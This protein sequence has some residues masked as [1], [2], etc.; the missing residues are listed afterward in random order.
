MVVL[1][2]AFETSWK[3]HETMNTIWNF[4]DL[5]P[6]ETSMPIKTKLPHSLMFPNK[7]LPISIS[8]LGWANTDFSDQPTSYPTS[9]P[10]N[11]N[12]Y[13]SLEYETYS[14]V[15]KFFVPFN[16]VFMKMTGLNTSSWNYRTK[17]SY[18]G[19]N[20][21]LATADEMDD[22]INTT[23]VLSWFEI[24]DNNRND[25]LHK[26]SLEYMWAHLFPKRYVLF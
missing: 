8:S 2:E 21:F 22:V 11:R 7:S 18:F 15:N 9:F 20:E 26:R 6:H 1:S 5:C 24:E 23:T 19:S 10:I 14:L 16:D 3:F 12:V 13:S 4:L 25:H 17:P